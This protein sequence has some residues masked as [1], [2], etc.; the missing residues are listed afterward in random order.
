ML[1]ADFHYSE[2]EKLDKFCKSDKYEVRNI[3]INERNK[4]TQKYD[5]SKLIHK[6]KIK[7][8]YIYIDN[9]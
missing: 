4:N 6:N 5:A 3:I 2:M 7:I 1:I 9:C 8:I